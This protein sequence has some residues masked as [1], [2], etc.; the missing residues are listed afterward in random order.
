MPGNTTNEWLQV[1]RLDGKGEISLPAY[2]KV[3]LD[4]TRFNREYISIEEG[5]FQGIK[6]SIKLNDNGQ[7][8]LQAEDEQTEPVTLKYSISKKILYL[9][10]EKYLTTDYRGLVWEKG[11]YDVEIPDYPHKGGRRYT[12]AKYGITWFR[13]SHGGERY[14]H[15][16]QVSLGC[17]TLTEQKKWDN[18]YKV[19]I[20]ARK[21]DGKSIGILE[22]ID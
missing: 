4:E 5:S 15:T 11:L 18:L 14:L 6:A 2:L 16:G 9:G 12:E 19:L 3:K 7:S 17:I 10:K 20:K 1:K 13:I 21:N 22:V 8:Y